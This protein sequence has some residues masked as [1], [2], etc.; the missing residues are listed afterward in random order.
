[1]AVQYPRCPYTRFGLDSECMRGCPG[2]A[3]EDVGV[4]SLHPWG[5]ELGEIRGLTCVHLGVQESG[6]G[7]VSACLFPGGPPLAAEPRAT[8]PGHPVRPEP[9]LAPRGR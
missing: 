8:G 5:V 7:F 9:E 4:V 1:M 2:F 6:R 3:P